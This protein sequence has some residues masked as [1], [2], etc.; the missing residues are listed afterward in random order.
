MKTNNSRNRAILTLVALGTLLTAA[1]Q[2]TENLLVSSLTTQDVFSFDGQTGDF[3]EVFISSPSLVGELR[4]L[5]IGP[6]GDI[7]GCFRTGD[8]I[9]RFDGETGCFKE[10][11]VPDNSGGLVNPIDLAF[12]PDGNLFVLSSN[13]GIYRYDGTTGAFI[14]LFIP[15]DS[16]ITYELYAPS[17]LVMDRTLNRMK[18]M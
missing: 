6:D 1:S 14:D 8:R 16:G 5:T 2:A 13:L 11:F 3:N 9:L 17:S 15:V 18:K 7:F 12:G 4:G 10:T